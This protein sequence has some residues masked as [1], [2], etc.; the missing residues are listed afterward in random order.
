MNNVIPFASLEYLRGAREA[1]KALER[2]K[3]AD[4]YQ[5]WMQLS[6]GDDFDKGYIE[7]IRQ[8]RKLG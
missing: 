8:E 7:A 5:A 4:L 6:D 3:P 2:A 1:R